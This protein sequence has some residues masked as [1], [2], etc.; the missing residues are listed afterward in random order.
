MAKLL[1]A[2]KLE[3][4]SNILAET[5]T[6]YEVHCCGTGADALALLESLRPDILIVDLSLPVVTGLT[7]LQ[8]TR[9]KPPIILALTNLAAESVLQA[10]AN[11]GA[12]NVILIPC[13]IRHI[14][15]HLEDLI[16]KALLSQCFLFWARHPKR[17]RSKT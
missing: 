13:T 6:Q 2:V 9:Y 7:V 16:Q 11:A 14:I 5:L 1:I 4:I 3:I 15:A 8:K 10:A 17:N 12:Q